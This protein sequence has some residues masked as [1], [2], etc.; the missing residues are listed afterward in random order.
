D[1]LIPFVPM[2]RFLGPLGPLGETA[3]QAAVVVQCEQNVVALGVERIGAAQSIVTQNVPHHAAARETVQAVALDES[4]FPVLV[5][6]PSAL[7]AN[8]DA[9]SGPHVVAVEEAV[10][11]P[12]LVID[13]SLTTRMLEQSILESAGYEV[14]LAV[15]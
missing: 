6:S 8:T 15:S 14:D 2:E 9:L 13:D 5:L 4:G 10:S 3:V 12:V 11:R 1:V 7:V